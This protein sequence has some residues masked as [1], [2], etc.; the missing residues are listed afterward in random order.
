MAGENKILESGKT[1]LPTG[2]L[3]VEKIDGLTRSKLAGAEFS[4]YYENNDQRYGTLTYTSDANGLLSI[5]TLPPGRYY[6][7]ETKA[8]T[9]YEL[10]SL[11][12]AVF[13][14][15]FLAAGNNHIALEIENTR[16]QDPVDPNNPTDPSNPIEPSDPSDPLKPITPTPLN[17][18]NSSTGDKNDLIVISLLITSCLAIVIVGRKKFLNKNK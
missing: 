4:L 5:N 18:K 1:W 11:I 14:I 8:P 2:D 16:S 9:G 3:A 6:L 10:D 7:K 12:K 13:E 17:G 15:D